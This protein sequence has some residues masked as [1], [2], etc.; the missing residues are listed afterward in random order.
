MKNNIHYALSQEKSSGCPVGKLNAALYDKLYEHPEKVKHGFFPWYEENNF[1]Q[2]KHRLPEGIV[3]IGK[4]PD[5]RFGIRNI[6]KSIYAIDE[7]FLKTCQEAKVDFHDIQPM[8]TVDRNGTSISKT[9]YY[10]VVFKCIEDITEI[11]GEN[12]IKNDLLH[13]ES[14]R[15]INFSEKITDNLFRFSKLSP[16]VSTLFCTD[17]FMRLAL[18]N[19]VEGIRFLPTSSPSSKISPV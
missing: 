9:A 3:L 17:S 4:D 18:I 5:Y 16:P 19:E 14:F 15:S 6:F 12:L 13:I 2:P 1:R 7:K 8:A 10:A 11:T